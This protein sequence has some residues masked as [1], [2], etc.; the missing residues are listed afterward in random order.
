MTQPALANRRFPF[1]GA[2]VDPL[3][4]GAKSDSRVG[5]GSALAFHATEAPRRAR[6]ALALPRDS[7]TEPG[8]GPAAALDEKQRS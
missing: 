5:E 6:A 7:N 1:T 8:D 3:L 2:P 4:L